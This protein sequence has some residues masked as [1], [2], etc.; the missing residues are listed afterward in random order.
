V[1]VIVVANFLSTAVGCLTVAGACALAVGLAQPATEV[2]RS[3][4]DAEIGNMKITR[5]KEI[6]FFTV[7]PTL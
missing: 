2:G 5:T 4:A 3:A 6:N 7:T 1:I